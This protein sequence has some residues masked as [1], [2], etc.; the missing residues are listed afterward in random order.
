MSVSVSAMKF[1]RRACLQYCAITITIHGLA[2]IFKA[3]VAIAVS[4]NF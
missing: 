2:W 3:L 1:R 4:L